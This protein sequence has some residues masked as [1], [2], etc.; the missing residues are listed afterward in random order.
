MGRVFVAGSI[1]MDVVATAD[2]HP[3]LGETV[4]GREVFYFPGGKGANQA[5]AA[6]KLGAATTL[7]GRVGEDAFGRELRTFLE[8]QGVDL[9]LVR[10][11]PEAHTGTAIITVANADNTIVVVP[12]ANALLTAADVAVPSLA[13]GDVAISQ[14]EIPLPAINAFFQRA[15]A[16]GAT[17][18]L[19]PAPALPF[20]RELLDLADILILNESELGYLTRTELRD[21][22]DHARFIEAARLLQAGT[23]KIICV[24]LGRRGAVALVGGEP[25]IISG[26][27]VKAVDTTGAGDS[28]VGAVAAQL[29]NGRAIRD[30]FET[31]N[32]AA[33][34][35]VQ[36]MG[37]APSMPTAVE[38]A[39]VRRG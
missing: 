19:N 17:T 25:L 35:C 18:I 23:D 36:R 38:V 27:I 22:D 7:I 9:A 29:A 8:A 3:K 21:T 11:A 34:I 30:A 31:A 33:S 5:V 24:T 16:A 20:D 26:R 1:N 2:R 12:G 39:V 32:I 10:D 13:R 14:F 6:A 28:F 4:A 15:R 37:A